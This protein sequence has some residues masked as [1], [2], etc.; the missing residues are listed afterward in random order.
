MATFFGEVTEV[1][2]RAVWWSDSEDE[3]DEEAKNDKEG[4]SNKIQPNITYKMIESNESKINDFRSRCKRLFISISKKQTTLIGGDQIIQIKVNVPDNFKN[5]VI[6][7]LYR[8]Q[9][10]DYWLV[11]DDKLVSYYHL[12]CTDLVDYLEENVL[13]SISAKYELLIISKDFNR[14]SNSLEYF[15]SLKFPF[16]QMIAPETVKNYFELAFIE[17]CIVYRMNFACFILPSSMVLEDKS[18]PIPNAIINN[19]N[20]FTEFS[21]SNIIT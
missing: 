17:Y 13:K 16:K 3:E 1:S 12:H 6:A 14:S 11:F 5:D 7:S 18:A 20:Q 15:G 8:L 4:N 21:Y 2:S 19:L 10:E 9:S